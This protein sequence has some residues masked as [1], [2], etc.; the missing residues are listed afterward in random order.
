MAH[1]V[2]RELDKILDGSE[3]RQ[4]PVAHAAAELHFTTPQG[5]NLHARY[6]TERPVTAPLHRTTGNRRKRLPEKVEEIIGTTLRSSGRAAWITRSVPK[7]L[8]SNSAFMSA[9]AVSS[10]AP[11]SA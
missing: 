11:T 9:S 3:P 1:R 5:Y 7:K 6:R 8:V 2:A 4:T 10:T